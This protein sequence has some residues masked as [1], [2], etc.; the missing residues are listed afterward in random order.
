MSITAVVL[1]GG[2]SRRMGR[3]KAFIEL[4]G[5]PL[6]KRVLQVVCPIFE[7]TVIITNRPEKFI[8]FDIPVYRDIVKGAGVLGGI[9]SA[10]T[11]VGTGTIFVFSCDMP[12]IN[13]DLVRL[14][15]E[16][17]PGYDVVI[18][19]RN[20]IMETLHAVYSKGC[21]KPIEE[22]IRKGDRRIVSFFPEVHLRV[23]EEEEYSLLDPEGLSFFNV[24]TQDDLQ[25]ARGLLSV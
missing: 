12:F 14:I 21:L 23:L 7:E 24:N 4:G 9:Y 19:K 13:E 22:H 11:L 2:K 20:K 6:I 8:D 25:T 18:P 17:S 1:A 15:I 3:D 5:I 16:K 10:L